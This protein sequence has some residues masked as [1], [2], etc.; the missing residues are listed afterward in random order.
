[1]IAHRLH[2]E[3]HR[4]QVAEGVTY[5]RIVGLSPHE[6]AALFLEKGVCGEASHGLEDFFDVEVAA[7]LRLLHLTEDDICGGGGG[8]VRTVV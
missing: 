1:M 3:G 8:V 6:R 7:A 4:P 5:L 2:Q